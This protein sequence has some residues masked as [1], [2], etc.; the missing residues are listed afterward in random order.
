MTGTVGMSIGA[1]LPH[2]EEGGLAATSVVSGGKSVVSGAAVFHSGQR[3]GKE[4]E[5]ARSQ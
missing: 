5:I 1:S 2:G 3:S 4:G